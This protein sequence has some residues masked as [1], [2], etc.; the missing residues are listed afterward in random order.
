MER[1]GA[2]SDFFDCGGTSLSAAVL[3]SNLSDLGATLSFQD[4]ST[5][6]TPRD[7]AAFLESGSAAEKPEMNRDAAESVYAFFH[8]EKSE[9]KQP[10][11]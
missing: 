1:A 9:E 7:L 11:K 3:I 6:P 4:I 5:H 8:K 10:P 2:T